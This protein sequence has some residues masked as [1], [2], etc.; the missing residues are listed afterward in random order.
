[1]GS[2]GDTTVTLEVPASGDSLLLVTKEN[3]ERVS[4]TSP[5]NLEFAELVQNTLDKWHINGVAIAVV[6]GDETWSEVSII[7]VSPS[8]YLLMRR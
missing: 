1:M 7:V 6:D 2:I 8:R 4:R 3:M 5:L